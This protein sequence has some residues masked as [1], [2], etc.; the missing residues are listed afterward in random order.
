MTIERIPRLALALPLRRPPE[1]LPTALPTAEDPAPMIDGDAVASRLQGLAALG[2]PLV[3]G[4]RL[5][6]RVLSTS[7]AVELQIDADA[8]TPPAR[9][10]VPAADG[11]P[12]AM[13]PDQ[14][15]LRHLRWRAP[16]ALDLATAL[17]TRVFRQVTT[18]LARADIAAAVTPAQAGDP[19][20]VAAPP[21]LPM[22]GAERW[23]FPVHLS[24][25]QSAHL[26]I[27]DDGDDGHGGG[28]AASAVLLIETELPGMGLVQVRLQIAGGVHLQFRID[29]DKAVAHVRDILPALAAA[30]VRAG[31]RLA[32]CRLLRVTSGRPHIR[33][34]DISRPSVLHAHLP[35]PLFRVAAEVLLALTAPPT[36]RTDLAATKRMS[37][38]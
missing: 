29:G 24:D 3:A 33:A 7:P 14:L 16:G 28:A 20:R 18:E 31:T 8:A 32:S 6:V 13:R 38:I 27:G 15:L 9:P 21:L 26:L 23:L 4:E 17:R 12:A 34:L 35:L 25:G 1:G 11:L 30:L 5:A 37:P 10:S 36:S 22:P 19:G 2:R